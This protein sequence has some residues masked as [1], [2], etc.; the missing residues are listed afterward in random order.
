MRRESG[1][2]KCGLIGILC[3]ALLVG[4]CGAS[5]CRVSAAQPTGK[6]AAAGQAVN[7][8]TAQVKQPQS[9]TAY[10]SGTGALHVAGAKLV[11]R[12]GTPVQLKGISTHGIAWFP[13]Y[14]NQNCFRTLRKDW[15]A[16]AV[17]LSMYT[18]EYGGY[19]T[20]GDKTALKKLVRDG[21]RYA[22]AEDLYV[23]IDWH[24]LSDGN[25]NTYKAE[26]K[27]FFAEMA[28]EFAGQG[29]VLY[30]ICNEPN[31]AVSWKEIKNYAQEVIPVI[32]R[33]DPDAVIIVGTPNWSQ[34]VDQAA[35]DPIQGQKNIMYALH[36]YAATHKD[37][38]RNKMVGAI[39]SGLPVFV[40]EYGICDASG[41][42][43]I[44]RAQADKWI[45]L[46]NQYQVSHMAWN[47][48]NKAETSAILKSSCTKTAGFTENDLSP[49]GVWLF[50]LLS[51]KS[52]LEP[53][54]DPAET[55][56]ASLPVGSAAGKR[57]WTARLV[58][59]WVQNGE[60]YYQYDFT[61]TNRTGGRTGA[62]IIAIPL[63]EPGVITDCWNGK[64]TVNGTDIQIT[65]MDYNGALAPG[66][67][68]GNIGVIIK[69]SST[70]RVK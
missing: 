63:S 9:E 50:N 46:L 12:K 26:A 2:V 60:S 1:I 5:S 56:S 29:N 40:T 32:R 16:N 58:N 4:I 69:G 21:V 20:G 67:S 18:A 24:I 27:S 51:G 13:G 37:D 53:A 54:S 11:D 52:R 68:V 19:C 47:L 44:D 64:A 6:A 59:K 65:S 28:K 3:L 14:V 17:R 39:R 41:S 61:I 42:G 31:G 62:W 35:A 22:T 8:K 45:S 66:G 49:A 10:F 15:G 36:F 23:L 34:Y 55:A 57:A 38:L 30:E 48:S 7:R 70:L 25:P 43:N 33:Y